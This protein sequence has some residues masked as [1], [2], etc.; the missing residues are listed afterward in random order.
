M[1]TVKE[2]KSLLLLKSIK[3]IKEGINDLI[4]LNEDELSENIE[5]ETEE[6]SYDDSDSEESEELVKKEIE[7]ACKK[8]K[9]KIQTLLNNNSFEC[10][11]YENEEEIFYSDRDKYLVADFEDFKIFI[12]CKFRDYNNIG[13]NDVERISGF[14]KSYHK[15][16]TGVIVTNQNYSENAYDQAYKMKILVCQTQNLLEKI[17]KEIERKKQKL[18][19]GQKE[20]KEIIVE[21]IEE[22]IDNNIDKE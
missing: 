16:D 21:L 17:K 13:F 20:P 3:Q 22:I 10:R 19:E 6:E 2:L 7:A 5:T 4:E 12:C 18:S 11:S 15:E 8:Y 1:A 9:K 14:M